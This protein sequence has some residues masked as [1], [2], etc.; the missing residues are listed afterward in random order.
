M[1]HG[2][3]PVEQQRRSRTASKA[4]QQQRVNSVLFLLALLVSCTIV[5]LRIW[6]RMRFSGSS[7]VV[8]SLTVALG[9]MAQQHQAQPGASNAGNSI[10]RGA[11]ALVPHDGVLPVPTAAAARIARRHGNG[12][13]AGFHHGRHVLKKRQQEDVSSAS[14]S[15]SGSAASSDAVISPDGK[16]ASMPDP[17]Q[18]EDGAGEDYLPPECEA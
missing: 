17:G 2:S 13:A 12:G 14:A 10:A 11:A 7:V 15:A 5:L 18:S 1:S 9:A 3:A 16:T 8:L 6:S 4:G